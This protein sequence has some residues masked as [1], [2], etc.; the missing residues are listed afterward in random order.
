MGCLLVSMVYNQK[1]VISRLEKRTSPYTLVYDAILADESLRRFFN[2]QA[3]PQVLLIGDESHNGGL[4]AL[5][6]F[7]W[8][9]KW[10]DWQSKHPMNA[11]KLQQANWIVTPRALWGTSIP[12]LEGFEQVDFVSSQFFVLRK[13]A[14]NSA[15]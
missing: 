8:C 4:V 14:T 12:D 10:M 13:S 6:C 5:N 11:S 7:G 9:V 3:Q 2:S 15:P 1:K